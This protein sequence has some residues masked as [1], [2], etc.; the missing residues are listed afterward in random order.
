MPNT[1]NSGMLVTQPWNT[2]K[3]HSSSYTRSRKNSSDINSSNPS[4]GNSGGGG[5]GS[6]GCLSKCSSAA[7]LHHPNMSG[8]YPSCDSHENALVGHLTN[9]VKQSKLLP[10][11]HGL[12]TGSWPLASSTAP[13]SDVNKDQRKTQMKTLE[14]LLVDDNPVNQ[15]VI[16]KMLSR[17]GIV[18]ELASNGLEAVEKCRIRAEAVASASASA[19]AAAAAST[20][21]GEETSST[22]D[23]I[24]KKKAVK[25]YDIIFMDIWMP[26][27]SGHEAAKEIRSIV[28]GVT[29]ESPLIV[30]MTACVM[31]GDQQKCIDSGMNRY[32]SKPIRKEELNKILEDWL[33][34]RAKAEEEL[35]LLNQRKLIQKKKRDLLQRRSS[36]ILM[37]GQEPGQVE[38]GLPSAT[39]VSTEDDDDDDDDDGDDN[40]DGEQHDGDM[41]RGDGGVVRREEELVD[42]NDEVFP[43]LDNA[44]SLLLENNRIAAARQKRRWRER[45]IRLSDSEGV[46]GCC[47]GGGGGLKIFNVGAEE[48][49]VAQARKRSQN[50]NSG[51]GGG[52]GGGG[53][54]SVRS[55]RGSVSI[56]DPVT[57]D[58]VIV[59]G[60]RMQ[61]G[62][63]F[64]DENDESENNGEGEKG[65]IQASVSFADGVHLGRLF[66][67]ST[68]NSSYT[69]KTYHD[70]TSSHHSSLVSNSSNSPNVSTIRGA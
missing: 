8:S 69:V 62:G 31:P 6:S 26:I 58:I 9:P 17:I 68:P 59:Q 67:Q 65:A 48:C 42:S 46:L 63:D 57:G 53:G 50:G 70:G 2:R 37:N 21:G 32:L 33:D 55:C 3:E 29:S 25:Q 19:A 47:D 30:A 10:M 11:F 27:M 51:S 52:G 12:M 61:G 44:D 64:A 39:I 38:D 14:C 54:G 66:T 7:S 4:A 34:E 45:G 16:S 35:R 60:D 13:D 56:Q 22:G 15:K 40:G 18:P 43:C 20:Q 36:A 24:K 5:G 41:G 1:M 49:R 23:Q 28:P